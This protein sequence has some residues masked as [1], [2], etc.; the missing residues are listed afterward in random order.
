MGA[1]VYENVP[2]LGSII[3]YT[4]KRLCKHGKE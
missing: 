3:R 1:F 4:K 2:V